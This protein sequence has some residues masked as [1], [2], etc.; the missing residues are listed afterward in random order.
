M[1]YEKRG[2]VLDKRKVFVKGMTN[3]EKLDLRIKLDK[4]KIM[5]I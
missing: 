4:K 1:Y 3:F 5:S 2:V